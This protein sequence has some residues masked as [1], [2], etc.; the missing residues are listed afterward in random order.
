MPSRPTNRCFDRPAF[1]RVALTAV[2]LLT[3]SALAQSPAA[4]PSV[5]V[6][7][8]V[9]LR[10]GVGTTLAAFRNS[11]AFAFQADVENARALHVLTAAQ[12]SAVRLALPGDA[13]V[14]A[15]VALGRDDWLLYVADAGRE[16]VGGLYRLAGATAQ[17]RQVLET[18]DIERASGMGTLLALADVQ[19]ARAGSDVWVMLRSPDQ[20]AFCRLDPARLLAGDPRL[21]RAFDT[22]WVRETPLLIEPGDRWT[23]RADGG[24][25]LFRPTTGETWR[26]D[27]AG[28][29][30]LQKTP[31]DRP[32]PTVA[33]LAL[34]PLTLKKEGPAMLS[35]YPERPHTAAVGAAVRYPAFVIRRGRADVVIDRD[36]IDI[37]P[38]FPA[39]ALRI[40]AWCVEPATGDVLAY[41]AMS[42]EVFRLTFGGL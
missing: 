17:P 14:R 19:M 8:V 20:T 23:G 25:D 42:G 41:D 22:V 12:A 39:Y 34:T 29:A 21:T 6:R 7:S 32:R 36:A 35:F 27:S 38:G 13:D 9:G 30:T 24:L 26:V 11:A 18:R 40:T 5:S 1:W 15:V 37:R 3:A 2:L 16:A 10:A 33:P 28:R 4:P 31:D